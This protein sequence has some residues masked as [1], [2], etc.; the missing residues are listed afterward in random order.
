MQDCKTF[1]TNAE[2]ILA[3]WKSCLRGIRTIPG[4]ETAKE[5]LGIGVIIGIVIGAILCGV[6]F[7][8]ILVYCMKNKHAQTSKELKKRVLLQN[9]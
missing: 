4:A 5:G 2:S 9:T 7:A 3:C 1:C 6:L 8:V